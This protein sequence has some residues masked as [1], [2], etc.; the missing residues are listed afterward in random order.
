MREAYLVLPN[1]SC[2]KILV[3]PNINNND[4]NNDDDD[5]EDDDE[6]RFFI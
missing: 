1:Q 5:N 2:K 6:L 4:D 3:I